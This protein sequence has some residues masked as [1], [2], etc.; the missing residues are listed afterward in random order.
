MSIS[1]TPADAT[2][3]PTLENSEVSVSHE[4]LVLV[5]GAVS[6][7]K[8]T[9]V[10]CVTPP[11]KCVDPP[12]VDTP[13]GLLL[14]TPPSRSAR[15]WT[16]TDPVEFETPSPLSH[17][18]LT[19]IDATDNCVPPWA[20]TSAA[21]RPEG[22]RV[23]NDFALNLQPKPC[24]PAA[25]QD[26][27]ASYRSTFSFTVRKGDTAELGLVVAEHKRGL[28]VLSITP[29]GV[30]EAWNKQCTGSRVCRVVRAGHMVV[31]VNGITGSSPM[32][33]EL[34]SRTLL[35]LTL[36]YDTFQ[37]TSWNFGSTSDPLE[38]QVEGASFKAPCTA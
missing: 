15:S 22:A 25:E 33:L 31:E 30:V 37:Y 36:E 21:L 38:L 27:A 34:M 6:H 8:E 13:P 3:L 28:R 26:S 10:S 24:L 7:E 17:S 23:E 11:L 32:L 19:S 2:F 35:R 4:G 18:S 16:Q 12:W 5:A 9:E 29:G 14:Q 1:N 20:K